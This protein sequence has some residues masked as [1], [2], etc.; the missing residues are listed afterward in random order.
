MMD[1]DF[2]NYSVSEH[3]IERYI[4]RVYSCCPEEAEELILD[5][6][7]KGKI[8]LDIGNHRYVRYEN[9]FFPCVRINQKLYKVKSVLTWDMVEHRIQRVVD[10]YITI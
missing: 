6:V 5:K 1:F 2:I 7:N 3:S 4:D 8:L 10:N 9:L